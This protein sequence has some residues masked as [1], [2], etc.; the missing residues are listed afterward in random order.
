LKYEPLGANGKHFPEI[1]FGD[2]IEK[3]RAL[4]DLRTAGSSLFHLHA[5][6]MLGTNPP[7][8]YEETWQS[9]DDWTRRVDLGGAVLHQT[10]SDGNTATNF[11]GDTRWQPQMLAVVSL[12]QDRLPDPGTF[13]EADWGNSA[14]PA[15]NVYPDR[16]PD[17]TEPVLIRAGRGPVDADNHPTSGQ[18]YW[19]DSDGLL[20]ASFE[21]GIT[22]VNSNFVLWNLKRVPPA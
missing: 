21:N 22:V 20:R 12:I 14:V 16:D 5:S 1:S 9:P 3:Y 6:F 15:G 10:R 13:Q 19:F 11:D 8:M 18:A 17:A 7:G 4:S 2:H